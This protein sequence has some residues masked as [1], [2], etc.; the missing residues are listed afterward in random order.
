MQSYGSRKEEQ[1]EYHKRTANCD[2][3]QA[4]LYLFNPLRKNLCSFP[5]CYQS[6]LYLKDK[7]VIP[8]IFQH[9]AT[10]HDKFVVDLGVLQPLVWGRGFV[11]VW[12]RFYSVFTKLLICSTKK[13]VCNITTKPALTLYS[14]FPQKLENLQQ[15]KQSD[16]VIVFG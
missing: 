13:R 7:S 6:L 2:F 16:F 4:A 9:T 1:R 10:E 14:L 12:I 5:S 3:A 8:D 15:F 11:Q